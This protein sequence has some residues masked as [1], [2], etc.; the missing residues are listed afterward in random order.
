MTRAYLLLLE[1]MDNDSIYVD[2]R[3]QRFQITHYDKEIIINCEDVKDFI[4]IFMENKDELL[5][6]LNITQ[7]GK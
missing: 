1:I 3:K 7:Y 4:T 5:E 6:K 2:H